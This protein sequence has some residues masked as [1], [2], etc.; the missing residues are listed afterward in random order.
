MYDYNYINKQ[1]LV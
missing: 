1:E